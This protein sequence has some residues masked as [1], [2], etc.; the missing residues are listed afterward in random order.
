[1]QNKH[2]SEKKRN[3][4][5]LVILNYVCFFSAYILRNTLQEHT[6]SWHFFKYMLYIIHIIYYLSYICNY[7]YIYILYLLYKYIYIYIYIHILYTLYINNV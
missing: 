4:E 6:A 5:I 3:R 1:M 7:I 2:V